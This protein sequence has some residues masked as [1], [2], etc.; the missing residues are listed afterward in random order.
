MKFNLRGFKEMDAALGELNKPTGRN[1]LRRA[2]MEALQPVAAAM[3]A[4]APKRLG[5]LNASIG[6]GT[7]RAKSVGREFRDASIVE[8]YVG[9]AVVEGGVPPQAFQQ[10]FGNENHGPQPYARP[11]WDTKV[12]GIMDDLKGPLGVEIDKAIARAQRKA[13]KGKG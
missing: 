11:G 13:L 10:E 5:D 3:T 1:V 8:I 6:V 9:P 4:R 2:G 7:K 12:G